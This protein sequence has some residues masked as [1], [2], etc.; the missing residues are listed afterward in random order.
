MSSRCT[1]DASLSAVHVSPG[2]NLNHPH[3]SGPK[4][5]VSL[6]APHLQANNVVP[7]PE[8]LFTGA[9][10]GGA[11]PAAGGG[12]AAGGLAVAEAGLGTPLRRQMQPVL[13]KSLVEIRNR[14]EPAT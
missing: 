6:L 9:A 4:D 8:G 10:A 12:A 5:L 7:V 14:Q 1:A 13:V 2:M 11:G 3:N